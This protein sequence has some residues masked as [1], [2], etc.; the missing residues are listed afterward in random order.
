MGREGE[1]ERERGGGR[2]KER[3]RKREKILLTNLFP[4]QPVTFPIWLSPSPAS[5]LFFILHSNMNL[6]FK[7]IS[8]FFFVINGVIGF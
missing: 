8:N 1:K 6:S 2:G 3:E 4:H 7:S 5:F